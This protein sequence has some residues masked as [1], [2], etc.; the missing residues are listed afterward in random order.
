[1]KCIPG[2]VLE[3]QWIVTGIMKLMTDPHQPKNAGTRQK[4]CN[5]LEKLGRKRE[6]RHDRMFED[7]KQE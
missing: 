5:V 3:Q 4:A 1:M 2:D 6:E 7:V